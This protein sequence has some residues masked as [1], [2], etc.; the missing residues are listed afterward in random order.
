MRYLGYLY[1]YI[2]C[3]QK[4]EALYQGKDVIATRCPTCFWSTLTINSSLKEILSY[5]L[6]C[7]LLT[8]KK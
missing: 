6:T 3:L 4:V 7:K 2:K 5:D 1:D 8:S